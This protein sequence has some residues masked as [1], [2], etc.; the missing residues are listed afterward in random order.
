METITHNLIAVIIQILCFKFIIFPFNIL[1]TIFFAFSSHIFFDAIS[2]ITY[3]TPEAQKKDNFWVIWHILIYSLS[4]LSIV[5]FLIPFWLS[6][7]FANILDIW[8][9]CI[10]RPIRKRKKKRDAAS[11]WG[12]NLYI[13]KMVDWFRI[14]FFDWLPKWNYKKSAVLIEILI[15]MSLILIILYIL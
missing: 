6:L 10:I 11:K 4:F 5:I 1:F 13:H 2:I 7:L 14:T 15:I 8:D 9:W 12:E 3:H